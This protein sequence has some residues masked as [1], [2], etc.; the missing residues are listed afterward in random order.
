[1]RRVSSDFQVSIAGKRG[2]RPVFFHRRGDRQWGDLC[3][4]RGGAGQAAA[5]AAEAV[6]IMST[7]WASPGAICQKELRNFYT[8]FL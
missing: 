1:M 7:T 5:V 4:G 8:E 3:G 6:A 2:E